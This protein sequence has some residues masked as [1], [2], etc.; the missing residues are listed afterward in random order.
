MI[1]FSDLLSRADAVLLQELIGGDVV[2][3]LSALST[4]GR[5]GTA[6]LRKVLLELRPSV[7][8]L[9]SKESRVKLLEL[10]R[11]GEA[12][13]LLEYLE[14]ESGGEP[15]ARLC[16]IEIRRGSRHAMLLLSFFGLTE[17]DKL[18]A[19]PPPAS[20]VKGG[21]EL[22][23]HQRRAVIKATRMLRDAPHKVL[24]HMPTG[25]GK[26]RTAMSLVASHLRENEEGL[27]LWLAAAEELCDQ[28]AEEFE[29]AWSHLG[30][31]TVNVHRFWGSHTVSVDA[32]LDGILV[33]GL[34]KL[35][36]KAIDNPAWVAKL[37]DKT[38]LV[39]FDEAHQAVAPTYRHVVE[40][41][42]ARREST[43][44][45]GLTATPGRT[46]NDPDADEQLA[47]LFSKQKVT[48]QISG[49]SNPVDF[50]VDRG[51]LAK[52]QFR[53]IEHHGPDLTDEERRLMTRELEIPASLLRRLAD[54]HVRNLYIANEVRVLADRHQRILVFST[55]V[56][57]AEK[58]AVV[59]RAQGIATRAITASTP[60]SDRAEAIRWYRSAT[61]GETRVLTNFGVLTTGFDAPKTS[62]ALIAR[63]TKSLVLYSQMVGRALR[64]ELA[65]G[66]RNAEIVTVIDTGLP[67]FRS[68]SEAFT[69][70]EDVW[71]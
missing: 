16:G 37:G 36:S 21:Y 44:L 57:H 58:L 63:P 41:V 56:A 53:E 3:L 1:S 11:S 20:D 26:T 50:L 27:V 59:L 52:P 47:I 40:A 71:Q 45:L 54:D 18:P 7:D 55:T 46:W 2:R 24:M 69:N 61:A 17:P 23:P 39:V 60:H 22:F 42:G 33:A 19:A 64:G 30:S 49:Y 43:G 65:G 13:S 68:P 4:D 70:W 31:R 10:L 51:Y 5:I 6:R 62:A 25:S 67:G 66:N 12:K 48:L 34:A 32:S 35:Y 9:L 29:K 38:S 15:F 14:V 8:L 28:A